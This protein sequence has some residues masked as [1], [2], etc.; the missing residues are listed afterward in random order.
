MY[1]QLVPPTELSQSICEP[2]K[3]DTTAWDLHIQH[4]SKLFLIFWTDQQLSQEF[5]PAV[6]TI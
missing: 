3:H 5:I 4:T 2:Q 1:I 6:S